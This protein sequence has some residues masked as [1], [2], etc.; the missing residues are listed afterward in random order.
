MTKII[1]VANHK[2]GCG[3]TATVVHLAA[4]MAH[5]GLNVLVIDLDSQGNASTHIGT[6]HPSLLPVRW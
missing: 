3:K 2:G 6:A 5:I 1:A 4:E